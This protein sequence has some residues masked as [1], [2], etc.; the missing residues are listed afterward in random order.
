[1]SSTLN[2]TEHTNADTDKRSGHENAQQG[3]AGNQVENITD[4]RGQRLRTSENSGKT[5][6]SS[7]LKASSFPKKVMVAGDRIELPF[8]G[9]E[10][11]VLPLHYP[12]IY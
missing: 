9:S 12:A 5:S 11:A 3:I 1:M 8:A 10:P 7:S 6:G 4:Q 2:A